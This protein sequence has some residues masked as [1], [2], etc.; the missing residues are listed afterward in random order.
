MDTAKEEK[1]GA[2]VSVPKWDVS[3]CVQC[4][5][6]SFVCPHAAIRPFLTT[7]SEVKEAPAGL[8]TKKAVGKEAYN[9]SIAVSVKDCLGCTS[10]TKVCPAGALEMADY[11]QEEYKS[12]LWNYLVKL[13]QKENFMNKNTVKG[14]QFEMPYLEFTG[15]CAGCAETPY[16]KV[17]TQLFG[18]RMIIANAHGCSNVWGGECPYKWI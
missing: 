3:K 17:I 11:D 8:E 7:D 10:C 14:S 2:S 6:C 15:A 1:R 4:N 16:A 18:D 9:F 5:K 12:D 13:P